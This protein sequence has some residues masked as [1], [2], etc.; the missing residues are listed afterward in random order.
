[1]LR[2]VDC[3]KGFMKVD[4]SEDLPKFTLQKDLLHVPS[5]EI[6]KLVWPILETGQTNFQ[7]M[8]IGFVRSNWPIFQKE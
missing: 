3:S 7:K 5:T 4:S 6:L 8:K 2:V 1:M